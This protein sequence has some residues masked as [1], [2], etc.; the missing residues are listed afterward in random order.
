M[1]VNIETCLSVVHLSFVPLQKQGSKLGLSLGMPEYVF[2]SECGFSPCGFVLLPGWDQ[3][4]PLVCELCAPLAPSLG[5]LM[6]DSWCL[7]R[8]SLCANFIYYVHHYSGCDALKASV[9]F[10]RTV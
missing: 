6:G 5:R 8:G 3:F 10:F 7:A 4:K 9:G 1:D 2:M